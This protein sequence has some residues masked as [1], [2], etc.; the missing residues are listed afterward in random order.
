MVN[1][2][3]D[4]SKRDDAGAPNAPDATAVIVPPDAP[5]IDAQPAAPPDAGVPP[6]IESDVTQFWTTEFGHA[7]TS[8]FHVW[9]AGPPSTT[10]CLT[11]TVEDTTIIAVRSSA[12]CFDASNWSVPQL[13][14]TQTFDDQLVTYDKTTNIDF[15]ITGDSDYAALSPWTM[16]T[17]IMDDDGVERISRGVNFPQG[18]PGADAVMSSDASEFFF[19]A[20]S[21]GDNFLFDGCN[22]AM[23]MKHDRVTGILS[24][25]VRAADGSCPDEDVGEPFLSANGQFLLFTSS[26]TNLL[27]SGP[28]ATANINQVFVRDLVNGTTELLSSAADGSPA[29]ADSHAAGI[30]NDGHYV[31]LFSTAG[32]L[33]SDVT[34]ANQNYQVLILDRVAGVTTIVSEKPDG[35][36]TSGSL[37]AMDNAGQSTWID[38]GARDSSAYAWLYDPSTGTYSPPPTAN[39]GACYAPRYSPSGER[40]MCTG[41]S[42]WGFW[43][44][45]VASGDNTFVEYRTDGTVGGVE[46][47]NASGVPSDGNYLAWG[48]SRSEMLPVG[49]T[50]GTYDLFIL[51]LARLVTI[52]VPTDDGNLPDS[53][54]GSPAFSADGNTLALSSVASNLTPD[55]AALAALNQTSAFAWRIA[56]P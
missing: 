18:L 11:P 35:T 56:E 2:I 41:G 10:T 45:D 8:G 50:D 25:V 12:N 29:N 48:A 3:V 55:A 33:T 31:L 20:S 36:L 13:V 54:S 52:T 22:R 15:A 14:V 23:I 6:A 49:S 7:T 5:T 43:L 51:D 1:P 19:V 38:G 32:N 39:G 4:A 47:V 44:Y 42:P 40:V 34:D 24:D 46:D 21:G 53:G 37:A 27:T 9:L 26:A 30:S 28:L 16:Q 17:W